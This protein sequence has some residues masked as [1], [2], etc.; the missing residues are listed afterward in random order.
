MVVSRRASYVFFCTQ[1][2]FNETDF[3]SF[4]CSL[5]YVFFML[6]LLQMNGSIKTAL[7]HISAKIFV[8]HNNRNRDNL[9]QL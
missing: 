8:L 4:K 6:H 7:Q 2:A 9:N 5:Q 1:I 3:G